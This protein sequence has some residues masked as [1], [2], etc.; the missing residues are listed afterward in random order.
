MCF[1]AATGRYFPS[2]GLEKGTVNLMKVKIIAVIAVL[3]V[4]L[5]AVNIIPRLDIVK[6][7]NSY[8]DD[9]DSENDSGGSNDQIVIRDLYPPDWETD[10][11]TLE[12]YLAKAPYLM[13]YGDFNGKFVEVTETLNT[14]DQCAVRGGAALALMYDYFDAVRRGQHEELNALFS[15]GYFDGEDKK[16]YE[17]FPMQKV[18]DVFIRKYAYAQG[19]HPNAT[20]YIVTYKIMENDGL[21]RYEVDADQE[22]VQ[23]FG[24]EPNEKGEQKIYFVFDAPGFNVYG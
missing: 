22:L 14:R 18:Y 16:P 13:K 9:G 4:L 10:I 5:G 6:N 1:G 8:V 12:E 19:D 17:A 21:F 24:V 20:Y 11:F 3:A 2:A 15:D 23:F 7:G